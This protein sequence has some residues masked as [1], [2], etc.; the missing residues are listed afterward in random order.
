MDRQRA[1][2]QEPKSLWQSP[3]LWVVLG[4]ISVAMHIGKLP[5]AVPALRE[6]L[7]VSLVQA[8]FLLSMVQFAGMCFG[9]MVGLF[10]DVIGLKRCML[11]GLM[12]LSLS[13]AL[14]ASAQTPAT[15]LLTRFFEGLGILLSIMPAPSLL[16]QLLKG[17]QLAKMLGWWAA[18]MPIGA[19]SAL[20]VGPWLINAV[21]WSLWWLLLAGVTLLA[22]AMILMKVPKG[23]S[24]QSEGHVSLHWGERLKMTLRSKGPWLIAFCFCVYSAQW[25]SV[26]GFLPTI[27]A[28]M[29][30]SPM[31]SG[32]ITALVAAANILGNV[33]SGFFLARSAQH[34][35][36]K[37]ALLKEQQ[38]AREAL[39]LQVQEGQ[40]LSP[41]QDPDPWN[42]AVQMGSGPHAGQPIN[43]GAS[44]Y[45]SS[46]FEPLVAPVPIYR[47]SG[48]EQRSAS[49]SHRTSSSAG[50][51]ASAAPEK[52]PGGF[53]QFLAYVSTPEG[54][55]SRL[56]LIGYC[57]MA[58]GCALAF[59]QIQGQTLPPE[60]RF[61]SIFLFSCVGGMVPGTLFSLAFKLSPNSECVAITVGWMQQFS[62]LGQ[63]LAPPL[64]A[65]LAVL[66]GGWQ[67]TWGITALM[68]GVGLLITAKISLMLMS[69]QP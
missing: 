33:G 24:S 42:A 26:V 38:E 59:G 37:R 17:E 48:L 8:G 47:D 23:L 32:L 4:G 20:L 3:A 9:L 43:T 30:I 67:W 31:S 19:A 68:A 28:E 35:Q 10:A 7:H 15:L 13:S 41:I 12:L 14:G 53:A 63:F 44:S 2:N 22:Y 16:R 55:S 65:W 52:S 40:V 39:K 46:P 25:I 60:W 27:T 34:V 57:T 61:L 69:E 64:V 51:E 18:Y 66:V 62:S 11:S 58:I 56:L 54:M 5:P 36:K 50:A 49:A 21:G 6:E 45:R 1:L 29:G